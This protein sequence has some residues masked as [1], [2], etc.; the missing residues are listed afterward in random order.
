MAD[1]AEQGLSAAGPSP[2]IR[3]THDRTLERSNA[4]ETSEVCD[5]PL[6]SNGEVVGGG[7]GRQM[8]P[9]EGRGA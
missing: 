6:P 2:A 5:D 3:A 1:D 8:R 9:W 4:T 7:P